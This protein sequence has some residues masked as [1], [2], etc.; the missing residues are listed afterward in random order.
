MTDINEIKSLSICIVGINAEQYLRNCIDS[1]HSSGLLIP[2]E[3]IYVDNG[4]T[5]GTKTMLESGFPEVRTCWNAQNLGY[6]KAN[7]QAISLAQYGTILLLNPDTIVK[8]G[9]ID[10]L[11]DYLRQHPV[12]GLVGPKVLNSDGTFQAHCKR[13][14]ARPWEVFCYFFGLSNLFPRSRLFSGYLQGFLDEDQV[15]DVPAISGSCMMIRREVIDQIGSLDERYF[16]YQEDTDY[17]VQARK[18]GWKVTYVPT[19]IIIHYGGKGGTEHQP[20]MTIY[21]WHQ[22]YFRYYKKQLAQD[23][24]FLFNWFYYFLMGIKLGLSVL[25]NIFRSNKHPGPKRG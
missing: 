5:D 17:C 8:R 19:S 16:A 20:F 1:I 13:G 12:S 22:S 21:V 10:E 14:E 3:I 6:A 9:S 2:Y 24:F 18:A 23:Y 25:I 15:N 4:S 7:N 11:V